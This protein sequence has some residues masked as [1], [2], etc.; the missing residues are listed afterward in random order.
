MDIFDALKN[1]TLDL[2]ASTAQNYMDPVKTLARLLKDSSLTEATERLRA[3][4]ADFDSFMCDSEATQR[5]MI[6]S[7]RLLWPED[8]TQ[9]LALKRE[10][11]MKFAGD[12]N[13][14]L[15]VGFRFYHTDSKHISGIR[16]VAAQLIQPFLRDFKIF[17]FEGG[18]PRMELVAPLVRKVFVVHG[19]DNEL[20]QM[21]A[22]FLEKLDFTPIIL[23]EQPSKGETILGKID[24]NSDVSF[25][26]VLLTPDDYGGKND[27]ESE[28]RA[29]QNVLLELGYF[30]G[31]LGKAKVCA[32][33]RGAVA[34]PTDFIGPIWVRVDEGDAWKFELARELKAVGHHLDMNRV[35]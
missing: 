8:H 32:L 22:R 4:G 1:A 14:L 28:P 10:M 2:Q 35:L 5:G 18:A 19:H 23:H 16:A 3:S 13:F 33:M 12:E 34:L 30:L 31:K 17:A 29:R 9:A 11:I 25:A 21:V 27:D 26:V 24:A 20:K 6:G 15:N 7:A